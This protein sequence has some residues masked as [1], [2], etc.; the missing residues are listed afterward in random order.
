MRFE[1]PS[2][3][4]C[5]LNRRGAERHLRHLRHG[6][7]YFCAHCNTWHVTTQSE[8]EHRRWQVFYVWRNR[9]LAEL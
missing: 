8:R 5:H 7:V 1:C 2:G 6:R 4:V 9:K 3:K